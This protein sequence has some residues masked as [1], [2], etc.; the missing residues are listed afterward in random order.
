MSEFPQDHPI[1]SL[2]GRR[3]PEPHEVRVQIEKRI[4]WLEYRIKQC[5][6]DKRPAGLF[7]VELKAMVMV[8]AMHDQAYPP[9]E[10]VMAQAS[11]ENAEPST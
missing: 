3:M 4:V 10:T 6:I 8:R 2:R 9:E 1:A 7:L 5:D 11:A